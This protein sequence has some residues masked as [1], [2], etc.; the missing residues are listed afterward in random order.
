MQAVV[1]AHATA[2]VR[3]AFFWKMNCPRD[4]S[5]GDMNSAQRI[6]KCVRLAYT[7]R[8]VN[9]S[10]PFT[11][12]GLSSCANTLLCRRLHTHMH[13]RKHSRY[14]REIRRRFCFVRRGTRGNEG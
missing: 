4:K 6:M 10:A 7:Y 3:L 11:L 14:C 9:E 8:G 1:F 2:T 13:K 12:V 5:H